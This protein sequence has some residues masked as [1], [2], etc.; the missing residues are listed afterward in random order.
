M[1]FENEKFIF[2]L[3]KVVF[4][5]EELDN[6]TQQVHFSNLR[7]IAKEDKINST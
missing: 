7:E 2:F 3:T 5:N 1:I 6:K 4:T